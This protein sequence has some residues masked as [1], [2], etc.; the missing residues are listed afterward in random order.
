MAASVRGWMERFKAVL[1]PLLLAAVLLNGSYQLVNGNRGLLAYRDLVQ[2]IAEAQAIRD[3]TARERT[4]LERRV[5][6]LRPSTLD[7]D[8]IEE[9]ARMLLDLAEKGDV[10]L[11]DDRK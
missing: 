7:T 11:F 3:E 1:G 4:V 5:S 2:V 6:L 8:M 10:I 9:R